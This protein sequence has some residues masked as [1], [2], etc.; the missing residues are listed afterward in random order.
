MS[1]RY[2]NDTLA[3]GTQSK[4]AYSFKSGKKEAVNTTISVEVENKTGTVASWGVNNDYPQQILAAIKKS[5]TAKAGLG[6][7]KKIH[8][9]NG[10]VF[11][12]EVAAEGSTKRQI[13]PVT[14]S[15]LPDIR[16]FFRRSQMPRFHKEIINDLETFAIGFPE[17]VLSADYNKITRV[18][19]QKSAWC[20]FQ[21]MNS[22]GE[23]ETVYISE[24]WARGADLKSEFVSA[25]PH[26]DSYMT[27]DEVKEYCKTKK[28]TNFI[29]PV[30]FPLTDEGYYPI[31]D[32]HTVKESGWLD[33]ANSIPE[34]KKAIFENQISIKYLIEIDERYF[35]NVYKDS[36]DDFKVDE[37]KEKRQEV[38]DII[39]E[40][41]GGNKAAGKTIQSMRIDV[42]DGQTV[43]AISITAIDDKFKEGSYLPEAS[44]ANSEIL[45]A[46]NVD[47]S[48]I[49]AGIPGG[50]LGAGSGSD[51]RVA[52]DIASALKKWSRDTTLEIFEFLRDYNGWDPEIMPHFENTVVTTL[53]KNPTGTQNAVN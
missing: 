44:A 50:K 49:G 27:A 52:F 16:D 25:V 20:R 13:Q 5:G 39:D 7:N 9:G 41:L 29:R 28:L 8:Y 24:K 43:P 38:I 23:I 1:V 10:L 42:G 48:I 12:K 2:I 46:M 35:E 6:V 26:V 11:S 34:L 45:F 36:W 33:V 40:H 53:D 22:T 37:R 51:K 30:F 18:R 47:S 19:R 3:L 32:W 17:Y 4:A 31:A 21:V 15:E 14:L